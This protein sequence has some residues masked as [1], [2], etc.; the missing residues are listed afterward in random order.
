MAT[1]PLCIHARV[2]KAGHE[3]HQH[4]RDFLQRLD[5][6]ALKPA[7][8]IVAAGVQIWT[9]KPLEGQ[10]DA[11]RTAPQGM[12]SGSTPTSRMAAMAYSTSSK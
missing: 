3:G 5:G 2:G 6:D 1:L 4:F 7:M 9:G 8:A 10:T 12:S 11:V